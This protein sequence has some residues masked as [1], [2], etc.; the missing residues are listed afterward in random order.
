MASAVRISGSLGVGVSAAYRQVDELDLA[1]AGVRG[2]HPRT[3]ARRSRS[4][5]AV[6]GRACRGETV[7]GDHACVVRDARG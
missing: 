3:F 7:S 6:L 1:C 2:L 4:E 5:V